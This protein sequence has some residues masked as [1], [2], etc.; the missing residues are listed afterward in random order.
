MEVAIASG[1]N[2]LG[3]LDSIIK[4]RVIS[5]MVLF[6]LSATPFCSGVYGQVV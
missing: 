6:F 1:Q 3:T 5:R 4:A 2:E